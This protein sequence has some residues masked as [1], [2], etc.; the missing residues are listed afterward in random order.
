MW[1]N[2][3]HWKVQTAQRQKFKQVLNIC[4]V[5]EKVNDA[6]PSINK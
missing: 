1:M 2:N 3:T 4:Y 5:V 6:L